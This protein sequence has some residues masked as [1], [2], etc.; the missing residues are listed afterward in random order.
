MPND[1]VRNVNSVCSSL[2]KC[3]GFLGGL[4]GKPPHKVVTE[5]L[6]FPG[7]LGAAA[8]KGASTAADHLL[9]MCAS[10]RLSVPTV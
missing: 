5:E 4:E 1:W 3:M 7:S 8:G 6:D 10:L 2:V 9:P